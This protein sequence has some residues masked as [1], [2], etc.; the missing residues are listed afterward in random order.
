VFN[1]LV[2]LF[3][4]V[5]LCY[6]EFFYLAFDMT[7]DRS[8]DLCQVVNTKRTTTVCVCNKVSAR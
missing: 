2:L 5:L 6:A 4:S 1:F 7:E 3:W 8:N